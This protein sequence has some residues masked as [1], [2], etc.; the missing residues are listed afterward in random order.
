MVFLNCSNVY[1]DI[2]EHLTHALLVLGLKRKGL[3]RFRE[4]AS[5]SKF[6]MFWR[7]FV[8]ARKNFH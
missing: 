8:F 7:N 5:F 4:N 6:C 1:F 3:F 2:E